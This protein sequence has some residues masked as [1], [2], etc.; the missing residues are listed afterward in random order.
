MAINSESG[1]AL[2]QGLHA[3]REEAEASFELY[4]TR[5]RSRRSL[6]MTT[7]AATE[8]ASAL[9]VGLMSQVFSQIDPLQ[10]AE[11]ERARQTATFYAERLGA[12]H[13]K[14]DA[15]DRL[16]TGYPSHDFVIDRE[17]AAELLRTVR[18]PTAD[19]DHFLNQIEPIVTDRRTQA[20]L[21]TLDDAVTIVDSSEWEKWTRSDDGSVGASGLGEPGETAGSE[22]S[23]DQ[24]SS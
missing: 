21:L 14:E 11:A 3:L 12:D 9:S 5:F 22:S 19:E 16:V 10:V 17:E 6:A 2:I 13:L 23:R 24:A 18:G 20:R 15:L 4:L 7:R 1:L 8:Q